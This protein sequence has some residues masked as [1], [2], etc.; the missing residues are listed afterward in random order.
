MRG[1]DLCSSVL[2]APSNDAYYDVALCVL[3]CTTQS[4]GIVNLLC[5]RCACMCSGLNEMFTVTV[6]LWCGGYYVCVCVGRMG[7][8][9]M[10]TINL[11]I[12]KT[13]RCAPMLQV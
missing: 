4:I 5:K 13:W 9:H 12:D 7:G 3:L 11:D 6:W 1:W 8:G 2:I 10:G